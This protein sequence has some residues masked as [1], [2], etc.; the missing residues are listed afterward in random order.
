MRIAI[1]VKTAQADR[2]MAKLNQGL[3]SLTPKKP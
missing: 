2:P 1:T 3:T